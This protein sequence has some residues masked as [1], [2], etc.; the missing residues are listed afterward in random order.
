MAIGPSPASADAAGQGGDFVPLGNGVRIVDTA[1]GVGAS[2]ATR[3][4]ASTT[5]VQ[6]LGTGSIPINGALPAGSARRTEV[7]R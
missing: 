6:V 1:N 7:V 4:P 2:K 5:A 3:G